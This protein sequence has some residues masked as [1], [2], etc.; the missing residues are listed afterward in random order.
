MGFEDF[1]K[2][3][4]GSF[5]S[6]ELPDDHFERFQQKMNKQ[7][8]NTISKTYW[9]SIAAGF[10]FLIMLSVF[11]RYQYTQPEKVVNENTILS[12]GDVSPKYEE[13]E[14]FYK[15]DLDQK[16]D[17][18]QKL[19]CKV[20]TEQKKMVDLELKQLDVVYNSL[21]KELKVNINDKRIIN[22]MIN[23]YQNKIQFLEL[24]IGQI[25]ENC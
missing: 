5:D 23:N 15:A 4:S 7:K 17:E 1:I 3:N 2:K 6:F 10:V 9:F 21:Q 8:K 16:I 12:L 13:V 22:A 20:N 24:V 19:N 25:K 14:N 18:F 11:I